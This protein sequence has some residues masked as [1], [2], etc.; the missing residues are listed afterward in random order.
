MPLLKN[1]GLTSVSA[2][3]DPI[4]ALLLIRSE[5]ILLREP[6]LLLLFLFLDL[7]IDLEVLLDPLERPSN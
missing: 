2:T 6:R 7:L 3:I 5:G 1:S 4:V